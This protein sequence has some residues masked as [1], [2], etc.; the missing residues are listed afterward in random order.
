MN[1]SNLPEFP[2]VKANEE[3]EKALEEFHNDK[4]KKERRETYKYLLIVI[5]TLFT[6]TIAYLQLRQVNN[7]NDIKEQV[8]LN[9]QRIDKLSNDLNDL[10]HRIASL[11]SSLVKISQTNADSNVKK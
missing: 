1:Y 6:L 9:S 2:K 11:E 8:Q 5:L 4:E 10:R 3:V 7:N